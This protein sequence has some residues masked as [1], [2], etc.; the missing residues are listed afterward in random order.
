MPELGP[1]KASLTEAVEAH[2]T[3][4]RR[5][6]V[7]FPQT[8]ALEAAQALEAPG[9]EV[10]V[11]NLKRQFL[12]VQVPFQVR[13]RAAAERQF[14]SS[15]R[16]YEEEFGGVIV[17]D[18]RYDPEGNEPGFQ[19]AQGPSLDDVLDLIR[20]VPAWE[21]TRG[22]GVTIAVVDTGINGN[23]PEFPEH[24][25]RGAWQP[26]GDAPWTDWEGHGTMCACIAAG[27][28]AQGGAF[29]GVAPEAGLIA[30]RTHFYDSELASA[31]DYLIE[32]VEQDA[33]QI[34]ATNSFGM[35]RGTA[36]P[37]PLASDFLPALE[38]AIQKGIRVFFSAGN[39]H[40]LA[41]GKP[42]DCHP[43]TIWQ[44]KSQANLMTVAAC[45]LDR[46]MWFHSS[47]GPGQKFGAPGTNR[48][49][50]VT[51]PTP[52]GGRIV[53]GDRIQDLPD[54]WG[55]SGA[56]PQVAGLAALLLAKAPDLSREELFNVIRNTAVDLGHGWDCQG[57]GRIDCLKAL[58]AV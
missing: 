36:P 35:R 32:R 44:H 4:S 2:L 57:A 8:E 56:C 28:R 41:S 3:L 11:V 39:N 50:D 43:T 22:E 34:V 29:N 55:T 24:K 48:K 15:L 1:A 18:Y 53:Y 46:S 23:R 45:K 17:D 26:I 13:G 20:A 19:G 31:Y 40:H 21:I 47:R 27:T 42:A 33:L 37:E 12:S 30:C 49:P 6:K 58:Q 10:R 51:A 9:A 14:D 52:E 25:R 54:G 38:E 16:I 7:R 5:F